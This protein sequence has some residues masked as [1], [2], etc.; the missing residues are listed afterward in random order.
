MDKSDILNGIRA[1]SKLID[2]NKD[3]LIQLDQQAG[4]GD[5][6]ISMSD[7]FHAVLKYLESAEESEMARLFAN[8]GN[9]FNDAA[10]SSLGTIISFIFKGMAKSMRGLSCFNMSQLAAAMNEGLDN[11]MS[12]A[13]SKPGEKTILD[14]M[15]PAVNALTSHASEGRNALKAAADEAA[16]GCESTRKMKAVWGRAAYYGDAGIGMLDGGAVVGQLIFKALYEKPW[17]N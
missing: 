3:Y 17:S 7:G 13:G 4:D 1:I 2:E 12:R 14:S 16:V 5:L 11:A 15:V 9:V 10:P 8:C 6:G